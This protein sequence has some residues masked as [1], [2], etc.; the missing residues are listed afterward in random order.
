M[1][2]QSTHPLVDVTAPVP[3]DGGAL[4]L[5]GGSTT[6]VTVNWTKASDNV[7]VQSNLL[8]LAYYSSSNNIDTVANM[9]A[10][11]TPIGNYA[12]DINSKLL[13]GLAPDTTYYF[14]VIVK[15]EAGNKAPYIMGA[16]KDA[17]CS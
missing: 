10:N 4:F 17:C 14:N 2:L 5:V 15:D 6:Q 8:Y 12:L 1:L 11:G 9:E 7:S 16:K 3:G 13:S